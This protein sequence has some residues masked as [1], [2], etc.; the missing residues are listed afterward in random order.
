MID[1]IF[2]FALTL[3]VLTIIVAVMAYVFKALYNFGVVGASEDP[4]TNV[5]RLKKINVN[6]AFAI[7]LLLSIFTAPSCCTTM[8]TSR[9]KKNKN[10]DD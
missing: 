4:V 1:D 6:Q 5:A 8:A 2:I 10:K 7:V 9:T 3:I